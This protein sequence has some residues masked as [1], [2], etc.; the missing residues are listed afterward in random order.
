MHGLDQYR[1]FGASFGR[2]R[3]IER[4][5]SFKWQAELAIIAEAVAATLW[6][7]LIVVASAAQRQIKLR[8]PLS[9]AFTCWGGSNWTA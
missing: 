3:G 9:R 6:N 1:A 7:S 4:E 5:F 2:R 8:E